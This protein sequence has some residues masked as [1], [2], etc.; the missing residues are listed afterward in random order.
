MS[1]LISAA[2][3]MTEWADQHDALS[4][5]FSE[6]HSSSDDYLPS[7]MILAAAAAARTETMSINV[8]AL[9]A[10]MY[11]PIKLAEDMSVLD[12]LSQGRVSYT[13]G[14]GYR[15]DEYAMF[16]IDP[17]RRGELM[18]ECLDVLKRALSG[19]RFTWRGRTIH[20]TPHPF[21]PGGPTIAYGGGSP[22]AARRAAR[23]GLVFLPQ[24]S[25]PELARIYDEAAM[26]A[27]NPTGM[28]LSPPPGAPT[29]VFVS[30][31]PDRSWSVIGRHL[32]HDARTYADWMDG[33]LQ[34]AS[35]IS[36]ATSVDELRAE[37]GPY[38]IVTPAGAR[39]LIAEFGVLVMQPLCGGL[40]PSL[41]WES[42]ELFAGG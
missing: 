28:C 38:R 9:L 21:T 33:S 3:K 2:L 5:M 40:A 11:D 31:D 16:G 15:L 29:T 25:D 37:N 34:S 41:A 27:G 30:Q 17:S 26:S 32:L 42:L 4:V 24:S 23:H 14:L 12:H 8:G 18:D 10:L 39:E 35:S 36:N 7:P 13:I 20:V 6:H 1:D 19:E 22:A